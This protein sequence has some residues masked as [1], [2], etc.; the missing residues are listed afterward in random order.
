MKAIL[1]QGIRENFTSNMNLYPQDYPTQSSLGQGIYWTDDAVSN[2]V[3]WVT[4]EFNNSIPEE[5][6]DSTLIEWA[7]ICAQAMYDHL[8]LE[9]GEFDE[10]P[11]ETWNTLVDQI[12]Y[13][14]NV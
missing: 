12:Q 9:D 2:L 14:L 10:D 5:K 3:T 7:M 4:N 11:N 13:L 6:D 8:G 1:E